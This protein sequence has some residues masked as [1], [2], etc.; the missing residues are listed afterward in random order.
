M[1][2][3]E[4]KLTANEKFSL[5]HLETNMKRGCRA[6]IVISTKMDLHTIKNMSW[7]GEKEFI[8]A[9]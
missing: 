8:E 5:R 6:K 3:K 7:Y 9:E 2:K 4:S 1:S